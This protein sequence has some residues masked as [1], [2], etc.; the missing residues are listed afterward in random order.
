MA[1]LTRDLMQKLVP[2]EKELVVVD[3]EAGIESFGR[4]VERYMDTILIVVEPSYESMTLAEKI[5]FMAQGMGINRIKA[6]LN[7]VPTDKVRVKMIDE[8]KKKGVTTL[9]TIFYDLRLNEAS[10]E[11]TV[12]FDSKA[13]QDLATALDTLLAETN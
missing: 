3:M 4:G 7:K 9:G 10:F 13:S 8:L 5:S 6:I 2:K 12:L 1:D 11:G